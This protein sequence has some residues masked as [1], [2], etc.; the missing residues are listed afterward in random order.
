MPPAPEKDV[1]VLVLGSRNEYTHMVTNWLA[2]HLQRVTLVMEEPLPRRALLRG[3]VRRYGVITALGQLL[4]A[5]T[6]VPLLRRASRAR[7]RE[8]VETYHLDPSRPSVETFHVP[9]VNSDAA[10]EVIA[11]VAPSVVVVQGTRIVGKKTLDAIDVPIVNT[12]MGVTPLYRG[13]HGGYWALAERRHD[14]VGTTIFLIDK[15]IDTGAVLAQVMFEPGPRDSIVTYPL[16]H[17]ATALPVLTEQVREVA[18]GRA[19]AERN[20]LGL[21][22]RLRTHPTFWGYLYR[23]ARWGVR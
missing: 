7:M 8:I 23:W 19:E 20:P 13:V 9:S 1:S 11:S 12:H 4:Y 6:I 14:L 17:L 18:E 15:G 16:L 2:S 5:A 21:P 3:R 10:R 22:S